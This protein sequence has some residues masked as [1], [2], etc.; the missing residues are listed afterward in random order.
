MPFES[1]IVILIDVFIGWLCHCQYPYEGDGRKCKMAACPPGQ[2]GQG[3]Q[4]IPLPAHAIC[5]PS[6]EKC[7]T[8]KCEKGFSSVKVPNKNP[9]ILP[10]TF[11]RSY[12]TGHK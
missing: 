9:D 11:Y 1:Y 7:L 3:G 12:F 8:F 10:V 4:C 6:V 5:S 2:A